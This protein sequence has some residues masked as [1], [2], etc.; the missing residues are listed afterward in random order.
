M[1]PDAKQFQ[2]VFSFTAN[3]SA[4]HLQYLGD[5]ATRFV[6]IRGGRL[7]LT[8]DEEA[9]VRFATQ[10]EAK[11]KLTAALTRVDWLAQEQQD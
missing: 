5:K 8:S 7:F 9:A 10:A 3:S 2:Y 4:W 11:E 1:P 6:G